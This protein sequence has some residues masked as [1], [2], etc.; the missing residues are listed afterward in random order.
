MIFR[1][2]D[3]KLYQVKIK[4]QDEDKFIQKNKSLKFI[5]V[6][7]D[8][9]PVYKGGKTDEVFYM[10]DSNGNIVIDTDRTS[11]RATEY[12]EE[13]KQDYL[14]RLLELCDRKT[15]EV[16][17]YIN[18]EKV[19]EGLI[20]RYQ[21]KEQMAKAYLADGSSYKDELQVEADLKGIS[22]DDLAKLIV[23]LAD[24]FKSKLDYF[25]SLIEAFRVKTKS[26]ILNYQFDDV[27]KIV[28]EASGMGA[29][30]TPDDIKNLFANI[31]S[32]S[33]EAS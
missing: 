30:S 29:N 25:Y 12:K 32:A 4:I 11:Q 19:T 23:S 16:K 33:G 31:D 2:I 3:N 8:K 22:V 1:V 13:R 6:S 7:N 26:L 5:K 14:N 27:D 20:E 17:N 10:L 24:K 9:L 18:G 15:Q 21:A 28:M